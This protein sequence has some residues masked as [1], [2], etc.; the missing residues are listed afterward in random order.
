[1][2]LYRQPHLGYTAAQKSGVSFALPSST[3]PPWHSS[4]QQHIPYSNVLQP[5]PYLCSSWRVTAPSSTSP[6]PDTHTAHCLQ[7]Y[8]LPAFHSFFHSI[9]SE[10][11]L[12]AKHL[13]NSR[14]QT[15]SSSG[16]LISVNRTT[17]SE[18]TASPTHQH[19]CIPVCVCVFLTQTHECKE[20]GERTTQGPEIIPERKEL[21]C[22]SPSIFN[23]FSGQYF[24]THKEGA[25]R[26]NLQFWKVRA[27][28]G[29]SRGRRPPHKT[30]NASTGKGSRHSETFPWALG[31]ERLLLYQLQGIDNGVWCQDRVIPTRGLKVSPSIPRDAHIGLAQAQKSQQGFS[32]LP[33]TPSSSSTQG[34]HPASSC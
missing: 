13:P 9:N 19:V 8:A 21:F 7:P 4:Q 2:F 31:K 11:L 22:L 5:E 1:M 14:L 25:E 32:A 18:V 29:S 24:L 17:H 33:P 23:K 10:F 26:P 16:F 34:P 15:H 6:G 3:H 28:W 20:G 27:R 30:K 12:W